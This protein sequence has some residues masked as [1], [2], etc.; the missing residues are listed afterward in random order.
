M[1]GGI[2]VTENNSA[3]TNGSTN[4]ARTQIASMYF[5]VGAA[6]SRQRF[7]PAQMLA[8]HSSQDMR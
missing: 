3:K 1:N 5:G 6:Q 2:T 7:A 4:R 8:P